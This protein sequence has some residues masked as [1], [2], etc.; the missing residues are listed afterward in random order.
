MSCFCVSVK[1]DLL[2]DVGD[3]WQKEPNKTAVE[4]NQQPNFLPHA[5]EQQ[6]SSCI[7][8]KPHTLMEYLVAYC[9]CLLHL[10][11][12]AKPMFFPIFHPLW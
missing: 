10:T 5:Q 4:A 6:Q 12:P 9:S 1:N 7:N 8:I 2:E 11:L 3:R